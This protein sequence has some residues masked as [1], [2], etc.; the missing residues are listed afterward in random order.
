LGSGLGSGLGA[1][2][3]SHVRTLADARGVAPGM[4]LLRLT[5]GAERL[6]RRVAIVR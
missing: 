3:G 6:Q 2:A 5:E 1:G 4:Y